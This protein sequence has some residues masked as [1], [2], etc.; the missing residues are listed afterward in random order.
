[1]P[2][3]RAPWPRRSVRCLPPSPTPRRA[4]YP[5]QRAGCPLHGDEA[6]A[7]PM[8]G[9]RSKRRAWARARMT[10][11]RRRTPSTIRRAD[12]WAQVLWQ[13]V[14]ANTG[15]Q[16]V[17]RQRGR[18]GGS[19]GEWGA[20]GTQ[21]VHNALP[22]WGEGARSGEVAWEWGLGEARTPLLVPLL[23]PRTERS[24]GTAAVWAGVEAA[25]LRREATRRSAIRRGA[26]ARGGWGR[27]AR[28]LARRGEKHSILGLWSQA[29]GMGSEGAAEGD[30]ARGVGG[31]LANGSCVR[32]AA[33]RHALLPELRDG[34]D[35]QRLD[36]RCIGLLPRIH[37]VAAW[38]T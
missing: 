3:R 5:P 25:V 36:L 38:V 16:P 8:A 21:V 26:G 19:G 35:L 11:P 33:A 13:Q 4:A 22:Q 6:S 12:S 29:M 15:R 37:G 28:R 34:L 1:M 7:L 30:G 20:Q 32:A 17:L 10:A 23:P 14:L 27:L 2:S 24:A 18:G 9:S 31:G